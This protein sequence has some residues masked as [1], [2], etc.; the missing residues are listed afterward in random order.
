M[1]YRYKPPPAIITSYGSV[2][3]ILPYWLE[4]RQL[5]VYLSIMNANHMQSHKYLFNS[6]ILWYICF[7]QKNKLYTG[8]INPCIESD[9]VCFKIFEI[10]YA[11]K[12]VSFSLSWWSRKL[13]NLK[14]K[15]PDKYEWI[16]LRPRACENDISVCPCLS[17]L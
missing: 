11:L 17:M 5:P 4:T 8:H 15:Y 6:H 14:M 12:C 10:F 3:Q 1:S 16:H 9:T 7:Q 13:F 2:L